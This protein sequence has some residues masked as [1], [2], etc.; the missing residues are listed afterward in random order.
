MAARKKKAAPAKAAPKQQ[1]LDVQAYLK[2]LEIA[3][4]KDEEVDFVPADDE[5]AG[6]LP[7]TEWFSTGNLGLDRQTGGGWPIT[8]ISELAAWEGVGKSTLLDQTIAMAQR[9]GAVTALIDSEKAR[10]KG[11]SERLGVDMSKLIVSKIDDLESAYTAI[12]RLLDVQEKFFIEGADK[13]L[14]PPPMFIAWDSLAGT[15]S[16]AELKGE[17]DDRHVG[18]HALITKQNFRR[19]TIRLGNLRAALVFANQFYE[20]IGMPGLTTTGG[21]G[22]RYYTSLRV[23]LKKG[24]EKIK[25]GSGDT[26]KE[27]G[28]T[29]VSQIRKTRVTSPPEPIE[30]GLIHGAGFSNGWTLFEWCKRNGPTKDRKWV[31]VRG[32]YHYF[33]NPETGDVHTFQR[34]FVGFEELLS[35]LPGSYEALATFYLNPHLLEG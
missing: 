34:G 15:P 9:A 23:W 26:A 31:E 2:Q 32:G 20:K 22:V 13:G 25:V 27:I 12:D 14:V 7:I 11:Y 19:I 29:V 10:D 35:Q 21:G 6:L 18:L 30:M 28:Q 16:R 33:T 17:A 8:R 1:E 5:F 24:A 3:S 4:K